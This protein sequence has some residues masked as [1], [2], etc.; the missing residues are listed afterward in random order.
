MNKMPDAKEFTYESK[1]RQSPDYALRES[2]A[3]FDHNNAVYATLY[4]LASRLDEARISYALVGAM[5][6]NEHGYSRMTTDVDLV[7]TRDGLEEFRQQFVDHGYGVAVPDARKT[8]RDTA[9]RVRI[10]VFTAGNYPGDGIPKPVAFPDPNDAIVID[11]VRVV[12]FE[13]LIELKL[14]SGMTVSHRLRDLAD[15]QDMIRTLSLPLDLKDKLDASVQIEYERLWHTIDDAIDPI[16]EELMNKKRTRHF[17][18]NP[19][20]ESSL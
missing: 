1:I 15:V 3:H 6:M 12:P 7:L 10:D 19:V 4:R 9:T 18:E 17:A 8:F 13:K 20:L 14:A 5:A 2:S 16:D 11:R